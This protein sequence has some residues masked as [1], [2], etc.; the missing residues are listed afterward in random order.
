MED[1]GS[2][3]SLLRDAGGVGDA[4]GWSRGTFG[5][6]FGGAGCV[7]PDGGGGILLEWAGELWREA[8]MT[9]VMRDC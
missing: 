3:C 1:C 5:H 8:W 9:S 6:G 7:D 2:E 4:L